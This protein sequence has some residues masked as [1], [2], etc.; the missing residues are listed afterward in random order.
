MTE[1]LRQSLSAVI[2]DEADA[3]ELRRVLDELERDPGLRETWERYHLI[4]NVLRGERTRDSHSAARALALRVP[5]ALRE[6]DAAII[7][8]TDAAPGQELAAVASERGRGSRGLRGA[9]LAVLAASVVIAL[10]VAFIPSGSEDLPVEPSVASRLAD[11][12][13]VPSGPLVAAVTDE[14]GAVLVGPE[15]FA[16][17]SPSD[18][19][20]AHAYMLQHAQRQ[21][22]EQRGVISLVKM[23]TYEAP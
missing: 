15:G 18:L 16:G 3:F 13:V 8:P 17:A 11:L 12:P 9:G 23:A 20:R 1:Q 5:E 21:G 2:D 19:R 4:G 6:D 14:Q 22:L 7:V 10:G